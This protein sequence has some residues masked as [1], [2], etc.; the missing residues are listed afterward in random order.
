MSNY[1]E[2]VAVTASE[3]NQEDE[4]AVKRTFE[5]P[6]YKRIGFLEVMSFI[7]KLGLIA[8]MVIYIIAGFRD[9]TIEVNRY[10]DSTI[11]S[12]YIVIIAMT[13]QQIINFSYR[14]VRFQSAR[15]RTVS[16]LL[17]SLLKYTV[18]IVAI[19]VILIQYWGYNYMTELIAGLGVVAIVVGLGCQ[20]LISDVI[21]GIFMVFENNYQ[22]GDIVIIDGLRGTINEIGL[23]T[24]SIE[25]IGG[26]IKIIN[27]SSITE[28]ENDSKQLSVA[29][30][31][32]GIEYEESL[33]RVEG[34]IS[35]NL[36]KIYNKIPEVVEGPDYLGVS[37]LGSSAVILL[38]VAKCKEEDIYAARR[39]LNRQFKLLFDKHSITIPYSQVTISNKVENISQA[40]A[41]QKR[42]AEKFVTEQNEIAKNCEDNNST[43]L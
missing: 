30:C 26:N 34:I 42:A 1:E 27:N 16:T 23:R 20:S 14:R 9:A 7:I 22:V 2:E 33:E 32:I 3:E 38:I 37:E 15:N 31:S 12:I 19:F 18:A 35:K 10:I 24:T 13:I 41:R 39:Q 5:A 17:K 28:I 4:V 36:T 43:S 6:D 11:I 21:A 8:T 29:T 40:T 25:D